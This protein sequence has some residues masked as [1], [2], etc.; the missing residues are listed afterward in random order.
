[1]KRA[2]ILFLST[3]LLTLSYR[4]DGTPPGHHDLSPRRAQVGARV[5]W[6]MEE[7]SGC[8]YKL[9]FKRGDLAGLDGEH[10]GHQPAACL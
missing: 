9:E 10:Q 5:V 3:A 4:R 6:L 2:V 8:P 1:M 7:G